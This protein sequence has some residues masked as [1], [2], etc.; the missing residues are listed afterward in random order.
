M[1]KGVCWEAGGV[2]D[3]E[4]LTNFRASI[5]LYD[6]KGDGIDGS[7]NPLS[8]EYWI[9]EMPPPLARKSDP[10]MLLKKNDANGTVDVVK[11]SSK[12][13]TPFPD[14]L[15]RDFLKAIHGSTDNQILLVELLKKQFV[16]SCAG[17]I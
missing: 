17:L 15:L 5:L 1:I 2:Q 8:S 16:P 10:Q 3:D 4:L 13:K 14:T 6:N 7:I 12:S 9:A 11:G